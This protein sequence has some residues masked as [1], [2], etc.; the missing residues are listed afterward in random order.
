MLTRTGSATLPP[1]MVGLTLLGACASTGTYVAPLPE[2]PAALVVGEDPTFL[3]GLDPLATTSATWFEQVDDDTL[4]RSAWSGY[5]NEV[6]VPAGEHRLS[7]GGAVRQRG[8]VIAVLQRYTCQRY[9]KIRRRGGLQQM[10]GKITAPGQTGIRRQFVSE[11]VQPAAG[12]LGP[13]LLQQ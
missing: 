11:T 1:A 3:E 10:F 7:V 4:S 2:A 13:Q 5:P 12:D 9:D 6:R 8:R